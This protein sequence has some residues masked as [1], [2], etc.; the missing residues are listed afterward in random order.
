MARKHV[1]YK[2][3]FY[4]GKVSGPEERIDGCPFQREVVCTLNGSECNKFGYRPKVCPL[5]DG[6]VTAVY[7]VKE[8][9]DE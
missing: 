3:M 5:R 1:V 4:K 7:Y 6:S 9:A 2:R 8:E